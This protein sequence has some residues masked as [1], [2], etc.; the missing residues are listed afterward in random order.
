A[1]RCRAWASELPRVC[2]LQRSSAPMLV[3]SKGSSIGRRGLCQASTMRL[4]T[5]WANSIPIA[6]QKEIL[7][8]YCDDHPAATYRNGILPALADAVLTLSSLLLASSVSGL[9]CGA[10]IEMRKE[11]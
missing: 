4:K 8:A 2:N 3:S 9:V 10:M 7:R 5:P 11:H 6:Q 1:N